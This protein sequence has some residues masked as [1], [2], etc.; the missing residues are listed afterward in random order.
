VFFLLVL[1]GRVF[2]PG[3]GYLLG[4]VSLFA[5][6]LLTGGVGPWLPF[7]MLAASWVGLGAGLLPR[8]VRGR[9]EI[10]MLAAYGVL[11]AYFYGITGGAAPPP[12]TTDTTTTTNSTSGLHDLHLVRPVNGRGR[13]LGELSEPLTQQDLS[14]RVFLIGHRCHRITS[15]SSARPRCTRVRTV[16]LLHFRM[17]AISTSGRS[18]R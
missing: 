18:H 2:G 3:F 14:L 16:D 13:V 15:R 9:V 5:S 8:A 4:S 1:A 12:S 11:A 17:A 6:A 7:Q 10:A